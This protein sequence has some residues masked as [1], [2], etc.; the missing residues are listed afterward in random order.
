VSV[1]AY[2]I[3]RAGPADLARL[4]SIDASAD[5]VLAEAARP[6]LSDAPPPGAL[7]R[8]LAEGLLWVAIPP[9]A[10][11]PVGYAAAERIAEGLLLHRIAV[12]RAHQRR[13][14]GATLLAAVIDHAR[15]SFEPAVLLVADRDLPWSGPFFARYGFVALAPSRLPTKLTDALATRAAPALL[16]AKRL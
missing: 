13:G 4:P 7:A 1:G 14:V 5:E 12:A 2:R 16:M 11:E 8:V 10:D 3:R 15:W 9:G 6:A